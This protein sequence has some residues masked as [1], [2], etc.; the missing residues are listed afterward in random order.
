L[1]GSEFFP[2]SIP[3]YA[4]TETFN[5]FRSQYPDYSY[6][7]A[8]LNPTNLRDRTA[9]WEADVVNIF[10]NEPSRREVVG[11]RETPEGVSLVTV[12]SNLANSNVAFRTFNGV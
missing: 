6:K 2:Q 3:Y 7:E 9:D 4:S 10:R 8:A 12:A 11:H 1:P 5:Y